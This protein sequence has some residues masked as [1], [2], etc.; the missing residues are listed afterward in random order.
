MSVADGGGRGLSTPSGEVTVMS[1]CM[2]PWSNLSV[3]SCVAWADSDVGI[4]EPAGGQALGHGD[5]EDA[6]RPP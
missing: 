2:S 4:L 1:S 6:Q 5:A 3:S